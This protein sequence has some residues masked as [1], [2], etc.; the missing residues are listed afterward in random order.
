MGNQLNIFEENQKRSYKDFYNNFY[1]G[2]K[3]RYK[4]EAIE[5][6]RRKGVAISISIRIKK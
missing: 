2:V 1:K 6:K 3:E 5:F 4:S